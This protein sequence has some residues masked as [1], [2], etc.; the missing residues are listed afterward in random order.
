MEGKKGI[1]VIKFLKTN[2]LT[3]SIIFI[4]TFS[5]VVFAG[6]VIMKEGDLDLN[7]L[8]TS[9]NTIILGRMA[10]GRDSLDSET[11]I[12][13]QGQGDDDSTFALQVLDGSQSP[14]VWLKLQDNAVAD[15]TGTVDTDDLQV[16]DDAVI[17]DVLTVKGDIALGDSLTAD[18][19]TLTGCIK[20]YSD[21]TDEHYWCYN[22]GSAFDCD[23]VCDPIGVDWLCQDGH[24]VVDGS[25]VSCSTSNSKAKTCE[26][27]EIAK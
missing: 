16:D 22:G 26:C 2:L 17:D 24:Y 25:T 14:S 8:E 7:D 4:I 1:K 5:I 9:G 11:T 18:V 15:I 13:L 10:V 19:L 20:L 6:N 23:D 21:Y 12:Y 27:V 3:L